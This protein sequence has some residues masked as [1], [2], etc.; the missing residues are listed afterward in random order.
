MDYRPPRAAVVPSGLLVIA[1]VAG[2][3]FSQMNGSEPA[4]AAGAVAAASAAPTTAHGGQ[5]A[6]ARAPERG[7]AP[8][9]PGKP[10]QQAAPVP[11][12]KVLD[13]QYQR[14]PNYYY[15]GPAATRIALSTS[16]HILSQDDI[17]GK[18]NTD[19][20]GTDSAHDVTRGLNSVLGGNVYQTREI[21]SYPATPAQMDQLQA[22]V[23]KSINSGRA[24]VAN[25]AGHLNDTGG[26]FHSYEG[27]HY[28]TIVGYKDDGR[29]VKIADPA[30]PNGDGT[31]WVTTINMANWISQ[32]GYSY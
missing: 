17:A 6:Q 24:I 14:Q 30:L 13:F 5:T 16:G 4:R 2:I 25:I 23:L 1:A 29:T 10:A 8:A 9:A 12:E 11:S 18:L 20:G 3:A 31:Y 21:P 7:A 27:G 26:A 28:L 15:C 32:R 22:D 19:T